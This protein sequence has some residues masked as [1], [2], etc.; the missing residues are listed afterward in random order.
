MSLLE[1][2]CKLM[3]EPDLN[4]LRVSRSHEQKSGALDAETDRR[5][6]VRRDVTPDRND[7]QENDT[8]SLLSVCAS[9]KLVRGVDNLDAPDRS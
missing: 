9:R 3:A 4:P 5:Q 1:W 2:E 8:L 6:V 7:R